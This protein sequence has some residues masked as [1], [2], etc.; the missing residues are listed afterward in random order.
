MMEDEY[1]EHRE[2][3]VAFLLRKFFAPPPEEPDA[4]GPVDAPADGSRRDGG[5]PGH[6]TRRRHGGR[7]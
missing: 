1:R 6:R 7:R 3:I 4:M 5:G 2:R